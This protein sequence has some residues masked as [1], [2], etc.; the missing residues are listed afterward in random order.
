MLNV[1]WFEVTHEMELALPPGAYTVTWRLY[2]G[3]LGGWHSEPAH[4]YFTKNDEET[5]ECKCHIDPRPEVS[6][7]PVAQYRL[8]AAIR[9][10]KT[11]WRE[12]DVAEFSVAKGEGTCSLKFSFIAR[13]SRGWKSGL[14]LGGV[15]IRPTDVVKQ[16]PLLQGTL[17]TPED[18]EVSFTSGVRRF[19]SD[20][21]NNT[22]GRRWR[23]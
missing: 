23:R 9:V 1:C 14:Y 5:T 6:S 11:G 7:Q 18:P 10:M 8:P 12:Y 3:H 19:F 20:W 15:D 4:F 16:I 2:L 13:E 22:S 17:R 21:S